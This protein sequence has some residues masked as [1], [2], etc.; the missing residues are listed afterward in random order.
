[1]MA[2]LIYTE[3]DIRILS[4]QGFSEKNTLYL[5][6]DKLKQIFDNLYCDWVLG[7]EK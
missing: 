3:Y 1:M 2:L 7:R 5:L 6:Y 4:C